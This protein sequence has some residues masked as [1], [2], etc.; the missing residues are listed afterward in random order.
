MAIEKALA[1]GQDP[2][3][4]DRT[5]GRYLRGAFYLGSKE[6]YAWLRGLEGAD[7]DGLSMTRVSDINQLYGGRESLDALQR[8][9]ARFFN[10][11]MMATALGAL[12]PTDWKAARS[13]A[14]SA[15]STIRRDGARHSRRPFILMCAAP[16][17]AVADDVNILWNYGHTIPRH[18]RDIYVTEY[19]I[20]DLRG[21]SDEA[22][23]W[24]C[25]RSATRGS[26]T[27]FAIGQRRPAS[28]ARLR[29]TAAWR[30]NEPARLG[31]H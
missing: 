17:R 15:A 20:A 19:G 14:A 7:F 4:A 3:L 1:S 16:A 22:V 9:H 2:D 27:T 10:I 29:H 8:R 13:S 6:F 30:R 26:R 24:R 18:L 11:C 5:D 23:C 12:F 28:C 25:W 31:K 21:K